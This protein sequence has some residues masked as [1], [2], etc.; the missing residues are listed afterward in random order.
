[1]FPNNK[2]INLEIFKH[3]I[4]KLSNQLVQ[5]ERQEFFGNNDEEKWLPFFQSKDASVMCPPYVG[6]NYKEGGLVIIPINPGGGN[7][8]SEQRNYGD[9]I[10]YPILHEF[11][12][13]RNNF[14]KYY[15]DTLVPAFRKAKP[16]WKIYKDMFPIL[17]ATKCNLDNIAYFNF[18][19]FRGRYNKYPTTQSDMNFIIPN[20]INKFVKP[21]LNLLKPS[22]IVTFGK[23]VDTYIHRYWEKFNYETISWNRARA[24]TESVL[25][26][27]Q[28][29]LEKLNNWENKFN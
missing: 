29:S 11:K 16:T 21:T 26:E 19:P 24:A 28:Q 2:G 22:L 3:E 25:R 10:L 18:L 17:N 20:S 4:A 7:E 14:D 23:Q 13:T 12:G 9:S 15:W 5:L 27:R 1:M 8:T 6:K